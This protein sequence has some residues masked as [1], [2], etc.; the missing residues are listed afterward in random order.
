[1][2][3][4]QIQY[5]ATNEPFDKAGSYGIQSKGGLFVKEIN[6]DYNNVVG[7]PL[8]RVYHEIEKLASKEA[9]P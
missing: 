6:G 2:Y 4:R 8:A 1:M 7:L 5:L 3:K 9:C